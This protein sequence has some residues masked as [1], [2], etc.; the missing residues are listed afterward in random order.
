MAECGCIKP[1]AQNS[2]RLEACCFEAWCCYCAPCENSSSETGGYRIFEENGTIYFDNAM[3]AD[4]CYIEYSGF[5][6]KSGNEYL[7]PEIAF[8]TIVEYTK[9][10]SIANKKGVAQWERRDQKQAYVDER[11]NMTKV[12]GRI[13]LSDIVHSALL[14]PKFSYNYDSCGNNGTFVPSDSS[15]SNG[16][17]GS[18]SSSSSV[19]NTTVILRTSNHQ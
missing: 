1:T 5:L 11:S 17:S 10:K 18:S 7:I 15:S 16:S 14:V 8:E 13:S 9:H 6:P 19:T 3:K 2:C 4:K 12:M